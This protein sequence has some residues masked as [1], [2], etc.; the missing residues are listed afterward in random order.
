MRNTYLD[1]YDVGTGTTV[2]TSVLSI[3]PE[4]IDAAY[5][6]LYGRSEV[7]EGLLTLHGPDRPG[8]PGTVSTTPPTWT[9]RTREG[10]T[11]MEMWMAMTHEDMAVVLDDL[12]DVRLTPGH[13]YLSPTPTHF[14]WVAWGIGLGSTDPVVQ[15][16]LPG[17]HHL[18]LVIPWA[19][20]LIHGAE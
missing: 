1:Y 20:T 2:R 14:P 15:T 10:W 17:I 7:C 13:P 12:D 18:R 8:P 4:H 16:A 5:P 6:L 3:L 11:V 9:V 19:W